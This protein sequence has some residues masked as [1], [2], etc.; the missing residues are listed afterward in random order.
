MTHWT[1]PVEEVE[2]ELVI[3]LPQDLLDAAQMQI[4]DSVEWHIDDQG[5]VTLTK[6]EADGKD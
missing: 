3:T 4:G 2:G 1:L 6:K 5:R